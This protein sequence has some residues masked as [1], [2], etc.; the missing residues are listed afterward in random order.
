MNSRQ[1]LK[2]GVPADCIPQAVAAIQSVTQAGQLKGKAV[3]KR[4]QQVLE[5]P[6][7]YLA[8]VHLGDFATAL[9][10]EREFVPPTPVTYRTWGADGIDEA[11]H[12]QMR[13]ACTVPVA[14]A[15]A[16]MPD[17]HVGYGLPIGG[18]LACENAVIPYAVG[19]DIACRMKLS[20]LDLPPA[21]LDTQ[22]N[23]FKEALEGGTRFGV[24]AEYKQPKSHAVLDQD[25]SVTRITRE[26]KDKAWRQ[27]GTSGSGNHFAEFGILSLAA[28]DS[29]WV[30]RPGSTWP[31]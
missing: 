15:A 21:S 7:A 23:A 28:S 4:I 27:L 6:S 26:S 31:C 18:V 2:L 20:V 16:L 29:A 12:A 22:F 30:W 19:V 10:S 3:K 1:L 24:G 11:A 17:A 8:D 14:A 5:D 9:I 13:Q 25:W